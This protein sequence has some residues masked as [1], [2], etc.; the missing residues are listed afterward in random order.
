MAMFSSASEDGPDAVAEAPAPSHELPLEQ[1]SAEAA[2]ERL[3]EA[4]SELPARQRE[5]F[6]LRTLAALVAAG[7]LTGAAQERSP[8]GE[9]D[10]APEAPGLEFLEYLGSW[11]EQDERWWLPALWAGASDAEE[12]PPEQEPVPDGDAPEQ[13]DADRGRE[14]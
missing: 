9:P 3:G 12:A 11:E 4:L 1:L 10:A 2:L 8:A 7:P 14:R 13:S 6:T 5:A